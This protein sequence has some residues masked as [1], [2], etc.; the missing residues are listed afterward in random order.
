[1]SIYIKESL[2][3]GSVKIIVF[4]PVLL[5]LLAVLMAGPDYQANQEKN[6]L[7]QILAAQGVEFLLSGQE[8]VSFYSSFLFPT[9]TV[10]YLYWC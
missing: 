7:L 9:F 4:I 6:D 1:M 10:V 5:V 2:F 3:D 8:K